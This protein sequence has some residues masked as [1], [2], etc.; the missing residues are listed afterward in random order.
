MAQ[1]RTPKKRSS[2]TTGSA[3]RQAPGKTDKAV[4]TGEPGRDRLIDRTAPPHAGDL[5]GELGPPAGESSR[6]R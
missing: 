6:V 3:R 4:P 2:G 5:P 1:S